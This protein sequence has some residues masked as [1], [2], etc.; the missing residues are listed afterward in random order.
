MFQKTWMKYR[1][2]VREQYYFLIRVKAQCNGYFWNH[3][4]SFLWMN[5]ILLHCIQIY[6]RN[7]AKV[8]WKIETY[9]LIFETPKK[10]SKRINVQFKVDFAKDGTSNVILFQTTPKKNSLWIFLLLMELETKPTTL[11]HHTLKYHNT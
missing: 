7:L 5:Q 2:V 11:Y 4:G 10:F 3:S 6:M 1:Y 8:R 9:I